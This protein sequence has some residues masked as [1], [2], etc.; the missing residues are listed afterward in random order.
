[1]TFQNLGRAIVPKQTSKSEPES[2]QLSLFDVLPQTIEVEPVKQWLTVSYK[3]VSLFSLKRSDATSKA[4]RSNLV[5]TPYTIKMALLK[6][7]IEGEGGKNCTNFDQWIQS[8]FAWIKPLKI[9]VLPPQKL[10]VNRNGY[11]FR[12]RG[13]SSPELYEGFLFREWIHLD[14]KLKICCGSADRPVN[15]EILERL[16]AQINYFGKRGCFFQY[17]PDKEDVQKTAEKP[18]EFQPRPNKG[19]IVQPMDDMGTSDKTTFSRIN[20]FSTETARLGE[21]RLINVEPLPLR[22]V[23]TSAHY[24]VYERL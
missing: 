3:P 18:P 4:A 22:L 2:I 7:L 19:F 11:K 6:A 1:M 10:V 23:A 9:Y 12:Y 20:P 24:D 15:L 16:F 5:P 21:E 17:C 8:Q 14:G 13:D